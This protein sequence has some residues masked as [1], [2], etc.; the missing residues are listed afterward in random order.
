[1]EP[2]G[3]ELSMAKRNVG[4]VDHVVIC[5]EP[6]NHA[7]AA[8]FISDLLDIEMEGPLE[9]ASH[10][11]SVYI[12]W[13]S[14]IEIVTPTD[15][16]IAREQRQFLDAHGEGVLRICFGFDDRDEALRRASSMGVAVRAKFDFTSFIPQWKPRFKRA[17]E[18]QVEPVHGVRFNFCEI[19][20]ED[21][22][23]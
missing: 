2:I 13:A 7:A 23:K 12:D 19:E 8:Q 17:L 1:V 20:F 11:Q 10:G 4:R 3:A 21:G 16:S 9:L 15:P 5:V 14:G 18:S 6:E 22:S